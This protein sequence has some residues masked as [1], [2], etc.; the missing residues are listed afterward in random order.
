MKVF[1]PQHD[2]ISSNVSNVVM[3][4]RADREPTVLVECPERLDQR[5][6]ASFPAQRSIISSW[7]RLSRLML[8]V[9]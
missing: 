2:Y 3:C 8:L 5:Y 4:V 1:E 7:V 9:S 6:A